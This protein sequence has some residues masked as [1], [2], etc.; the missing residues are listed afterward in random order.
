MKSDKAICD[1]PSNVGKYIEDFTCRGL[2]ST[3]R[4][5]KEVSLSFPSGHS[6]FT[7][8]TMVYTAVNAILIIELCNVSHTK[9][10]FKIDILAIP[11]ELAR[12]KVVEAFFAVLINHNCMVYGIESS[13]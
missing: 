4:M 3:E 12:I 13:L 1:D 10:L 6:S 8:Y 2:N 9:V 5:L 11:N 7:F